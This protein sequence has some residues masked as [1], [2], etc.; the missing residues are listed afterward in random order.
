MNMLIN[1]LVYQLCWFACIL[2]GANGMPLLG[3]AIVMLAVAYHLFNAP[4]PRSEFILMAIAAVI[5]GTWDSLLVAMGWLVYPSGTLVAGTAPYWIVALWVAFATTFNVSLSWF[6]K[7]LAL[8]ALCGA[9]GGPLAF[10]AGE[11]LGGVVFTSYP[12]GLGM[13]ALGWTL[14]M[15]LMLLIARHF[16]GFAQTQRSTTATTANGAST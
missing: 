6:K 15:P 13:L 11:R 7:H 14:L 1:V 4:A 9:V 3:V 10:L 16:D 8:A 2:G 12:A 5:G